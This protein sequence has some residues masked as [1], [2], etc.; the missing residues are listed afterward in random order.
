MTRTA[1][2]LSVGCGVGGSG[3]RL[4]LWPVPE[5]GFAKRTAAVGGVEADVGPA[6]R[7]HGEDERE[8]TVALIYEGR[9]GWEGAG[10]IVRAC[11]GGIGGKHGRSWEAR[12]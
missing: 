3:G 12:V 8:G 11:G 5:G 2:Y 7:C 6:L 1:A 9:L 4:V 10:A